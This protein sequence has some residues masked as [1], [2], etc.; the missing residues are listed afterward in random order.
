MVPEILP[1]KDE[2]IVTMIQR[3][4]TRGQGSREGFLPSI[5]L[6]QYR[7]GNKVQPLDTD[8]NHCH[9]LW[10]NKRLGNGFN[11]IK[12]LTAVPKSKKEATT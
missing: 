3:R 7:S 8:V 1:K 5:G 11:N 12:P 10:R 9:K 2:Y 4:F 6:G